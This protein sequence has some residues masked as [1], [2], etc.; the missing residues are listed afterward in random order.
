MVNKIIIQASSPYPLVPGTGS[1]KLAPLIIGIAFFNDRAFFLAFAFFFFSNLIALALARVFSVV[2]IIEH[3][4]QFIKYLLF[5]IP[6]QLIKNGLS[7]VLT[8]KDSISG[9]FSES[10]IALLL[11]LLLFINSSL[12]ISSL[13]SF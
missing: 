3:H 2:S 13:L 8:F 6:F 4:L 9:L 1:Q 5:L 11:S 12:F 10:R 7:L